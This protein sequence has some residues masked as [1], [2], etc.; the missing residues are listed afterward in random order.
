MGKSKEDTAY[1]YAAGI[2]DGEGYIAVPPRK[3]KRPGTP[4]IQVEMTSHEIIKFL[5]NLFQVGSVQKPK[6][7]QPHHLQ[8]WKWTVKYRQAYKTAEKVW[9]YIV[10]KK[11]KI[12]CILSYYK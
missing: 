9:P 10:H 12:Y 7:R 1:A 2:L 11:D 6:K 5:Y 4:I 8:S 3:D